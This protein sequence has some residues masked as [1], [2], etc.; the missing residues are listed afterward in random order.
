MNTLIQNYAETLREAPARAAALARSLQEALGKARAYTDPNLSSEG[1]QQKREELAKQF[2]EAGSVDLEKLEL[3]VRVSHRAFTERATALMHIPQRS[4]DLIRAEQKWRQVETMLNAGQS[5]QGI[6]AAA[7]EVTVRAI[8]EWVPS[9]LA[10]QSRAR[11]D[12][13]SAIRSWLGQEPTDTAA[14]LRGPLYARLSEVLSDPESREL[15]AGASTADSH[16]AAAQPWLTAARSWVEYGSADMLGTAI[17]AAAITGSS[18]RG[19]APAE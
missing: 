4:A 13:D 18:T 6:I 9:W 16:L 15:A 2:R 12:I 17:A 10:T 3:D 14:A 19:E 5:L 11:T 1:L 7:D 8:A